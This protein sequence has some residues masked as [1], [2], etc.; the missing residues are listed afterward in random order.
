MKAIALPFRHTGP[1]RVS[2]ERRRRTEGEGEAVRELER[3]GR[4]EEKGTEQSTADGLRMRGWHKG[5]LPS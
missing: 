2:A 5:S 3:V 1:Q 4:P